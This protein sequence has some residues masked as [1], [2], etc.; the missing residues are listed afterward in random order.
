MNCNIKRHAYVD[1]TGNPYIYYHGIPHERNA[2]IPN[3]NQNDNLNRTVIRTV[4]PNNVFSTHV[5]LNGFGNL[6]GNVNQKY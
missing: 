1:F 3:L 4:F 5:P 2:Y 6:K